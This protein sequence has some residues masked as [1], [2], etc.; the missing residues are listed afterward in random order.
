VHITKGYVRNFADRYMD[1]DYIWEFKTALTRDQNNLILSP[2]GRISLNIPQYQLPADG[3]IEF[4]E[5][6]P[7]NTPAE[8]SQLSLTSANDAETSW[9]NPY[10]YQFSDI[11]TEIV[12]YSGGSSYVVPSFT[13]N[14]EIKIDYSGYLTESDSEYLSMPG[15]PPIKEETL[16]IYYLDESIEK[17]IPLSTAVDT[18]DNILSANIRHFSVYSIMGSQNYNVENAHPFPV[19]Y[20]A[21]EVPDAFKGTIRSGITFTSL[22][23]EC[24]LTIYTIAGRKVFD[25][26]HSDADTQSGGQVGNSYWYPVVNSHGSDVASGVYIYHIKSE[27]SSKTG[28]LM[29]IR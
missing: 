13:E 4:T 10:H 6:I 14:I 1:E 19:P 7:P 15:K 20:R 21:S 16:K 27:N 12:F 9:D 29:I 18:Q 24:D 26:H 17:W 23:S 8:T 25:I 5:S 28:K 2:S 3:L 11:T 22:A